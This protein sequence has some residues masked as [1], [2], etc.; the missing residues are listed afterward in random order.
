MQINEVVREE[1]FLK[2]GKLTAIKINLKKTLP[3]RK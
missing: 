2:L 3:Q 1:E